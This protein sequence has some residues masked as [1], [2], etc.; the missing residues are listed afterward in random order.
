MQRLLS[1]N[2]FRTGRSPQRRFSYSDINDNFKAGL[3]KYNISG[4][5]IKNDT[6]VYGLVGIKSDNF[7]AIKVKVQ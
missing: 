1:R 6:T 3:L 7:D 2:K 4:S 5:L